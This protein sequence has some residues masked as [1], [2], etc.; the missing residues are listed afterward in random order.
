MLAFRQ[1]LRTEILAI[2]VQQVEGNEVCRTTVEQEILELW[3][4]V[5]VQAHNLAIQHGSAYVRQLACDRRA[6]LTEGRERIAVTRDQMAPAITQTG[7]RTEAVVLQLKQPVRI[8]E[9]LGPDSQP[10]RLES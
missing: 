8:I 3:S 9:G 2:P 4:P 10:K 5:L 1:T 7:E 6:K